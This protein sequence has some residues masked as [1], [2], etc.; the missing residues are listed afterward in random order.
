M[1][2]FVQITLFS[3][4]LI[5]APQV[6][7]QSKELWSPTLAPL[8]HSQ[9]LERK[10]TIKKYKAYELNLTALKG[11]LADAPQKTTLLEKS[12]TIVKFPDADGV[13]SNFEV[14]EAGVME[15]ELALKFPDNKS[16][17]AYAVADKST[18]IRFSL[19]QLGLY[20]TIFKAGKQTQ[21]IEPNSKDRLNY[22][23]YSRENLDEQ[24]QVF[25]CST[26]EITLPNINA[27]AKTFNTNDAKLRTF[28]LAVATTG[29]YSQFHINAAGLSLGSDA[30][31]KAAVLAAI[32]TTITR[33]NAIF[34]RD[35]ALSLVLVAN[36]DQLIYL[37]GATDPY[38][39]NNGNTML[40]QNQT[41][42][43]N[44]IGSPNYDIGHVFSTAGGGIAVLN[45]PCT[46]SKAQGVT[47][48]TNP[49]GDAFDI[50]F[51]V[52]EMGHQFGAS[53]TFNGDAGS[54]S[55]GNR[56]DLTAVEP[57]SGSTIM[58]Y[59]GIC[60]PQN[61]QLHSDDYFHSISIQQMFTS[62]STGFNN[63]GIASSLINNQNAPVINAQA[64][65]IIP[66]LTP[67]K[68]NAIATDADND[69]LTYT[70]EQTDNQITSIPPSATATGGAIFRSIAP[71]ISSSRIFPEINTILAGQ[72]ANTWEVLP[73][74]AR[75]LNFDVTVRDN[76]INGGQT[77]RE[78]KIITVNDTAG[79]FIV[80]SQNT[81]V[82]YD[83][84]SMQL[85]TWN[86]AVTDLAPINC[87]FVDL[88]LSTDGGQSYPIILASN[89]PN[90]GSYEVF[91]P[92]NPTNTARIMVASVGNVFFNI[93]TSN[94]SI[95]QNLMALLPAAEFSE[96]CAG[97]QVVL[98]YTY[99]S[100]GGFAETADFSVINLPSGMTANFN[101]I[102]TSANGTLIQLTLSGISNLNLGSNSIT[103]KA[104]TPSINRLI[105]NKLQVYD[106]T[107]STQTLTA[108]S[109]GALGVR[110][111][112]TLSWDLQSNAKSYELQVA[113]D[114]GFSN[115]IATANTTNSN[116]T[117][118]GLA[119]ATAY[120]WRVK[121][122]NSCATGAYS[123]INVFATYQQTCATTSY[124]GL[125]LA[126]PDNNAIGVSSTIS[127]AE[128][129]IM[130][131]VKIGINVSHPFI[132][133]LKITL[134]S[135]SGKT[136]QLLN[137]SNCA[138]QDMNAIFTDAGTILVC[139]NSVPGYSG[140]L[141]PAEAFTAYIGDNAQGDWKLFLEDQGP[142]GIGTLVGWNIEVCNDV[143]VPLA[144]D[145]QV[146]NP[147][148]IWPN[149]TNGVLNISLPNAD[150]NL[151]RIQ[152]MDVLGRKIEQFNLNAPNKSINL[153]NLQNGIYY[154]KIIEGTHFYIKKIIK[155]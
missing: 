26:A 150:L 39:N 142:G 103:V 75:T 146:L 58:A 68:L 10:T 111:N 72:T 124:S 138:T 18:S 127:V 77:A 35:V 61:V 154:L 19:N 133:D 38:T 109:Q 80:T 108:P 11:L 42:I 143:S 47:G 59:A 148:L 113:T 121:P 134:T 34:E 52:H 155:N 86:V 119:E 153:N 123:S 85:I 83:V 84:G 2:Y 92:N 28:R 27:F 50:D 110:L 36:N 126:I 76:H 17:I 89:V 53:H 118:S 81:P 102:S 112:P 46:S 51:V 90:N 21:Y 74:V 4:F 87:A 45:S 67:F 130:S 70:W 71:A 141:K 5:F 144:V 152:I 62:I 6:F 7:S 25:V 120:Y 107:F 122:I 94:F 140:N 54:C 149:P 30:Q 131:A 57:G 96:T 69:A 13:L 136:I 79:P 3:F 60:S 91:I 129:T 137:A 104:H 14:F 66:K 106:A 55:G 65:A 16:Y 78:S 100:F 43:N 12:K 105:T 128:N 147:F 64:D 135:P 95:Q 40:I 117:L 115:L 88:L 73:S 97:N 125:A 48:Q 31:K 82:T 98:N 56:N 93:N 114:I 29:E 151:I 63:C 22:T 33:V 101:P 20:A 44:V 1:K 37:D 99:Q 132:G 145:K 9:L 15:P 41:T 139:N 23:V 116:Y 8:K 32:T 49:V 24:N